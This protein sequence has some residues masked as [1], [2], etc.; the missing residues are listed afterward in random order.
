MSNF[1]HIGGPGEDIEVEISANS[2]LTIRATLSDPPSPGNQGTIT[3]TLPLE[4]N[5]NLLELAELDSDGFRA[6]C[7]KVGVQLLGLGHLYLACIKI[8]SAHLP[9]GILLLTCLNEGLAG[10]SR[11]IKCVGQ[12]GRR[13]Y[14]LGEEDLT[15]SDCL[16]DLIE[17]GRFPNS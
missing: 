16:Q 11:Q 3:C 8:T 14:E 10:I 6:F 7:R 4:E 12:V 9:T 5:S 1:R 15:P 17:A 13:A 2:L